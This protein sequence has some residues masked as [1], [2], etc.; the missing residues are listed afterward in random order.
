MNGIQTVIVRIRSIDNG[1]IFQGYLSKLGLPGNVVD[2]HII[3]HIARLQR[4]DNDGVFRDCLVD[5]LGNG[6]VIDRVNLNTHGRNIRNINTITH[7]VGKAVLPIRVF[8]RGVDNIGNSSAERSAGRLRP[9]LIDQR[10][11]FL[12]KSAQRDG[13]GRVLV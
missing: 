12:V 2:Q 1:I 6:L 11:I 10:I 5:W 9:N 13:Q 3:I 4:N 7:P 8:I